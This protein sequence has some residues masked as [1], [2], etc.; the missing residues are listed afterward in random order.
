[1]T[2]LLLALLTANSLS[3][4]DPP[5]VFRVWVASDCHLTAD[6]RHGRESLAEAIRQSEGRQA[7]A[8]PFAWDIMVDAGD[9]SA[10]QFPPTDEDGRELVRQYRA[11]SKHNREDVYNV[12]GNHDGTYY[13]RGVAWWFRKWADPLGEHT[14]LSGVDASRRPFPIEGTWERYR[15][16]AGNVVFL[17][18]S[19]RNSAPAP[20][21]RGRS[22]QKL[23]GGFPAGA[24]TRETFDWWKRQVLDNQDK[25]LIT[26]HHHVLRDTTTRSGYGEGEGFH[27]KSGG[28]EGSS[29]LYFT[30]E[31]ECPKQFEY[32]TSTPEDPGPFERFLEQFHQENGRAA[33]DLWIGGHSH[34]MTP[35]QSFNGKG[36]AE[37][38]WGVTFLQV[39]GL[40]RYHAGGIPS[41]RL[42]TF[43]GGGRKLDVKLYLHE[44]YEDASVGWYRPAARTVTLRHTFRPPVPSGAGGTGAR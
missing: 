12:P 37:K 5:P 8:P 10:S 29:Y 25:I 6:I 17:M 23:K 40:T 32:S 20:V 9:L 16:A 14:E 4:A 34:A 15:F 35:D 26:V 13:D 30:I 33:I 19:D 28:V 3:L 18:L 36:L 31:N 2:S 22:D 24:V 7:G 27:G 1:M 42:L 41:S 11:L 38:K 43:T 21:G 44:P 39:S